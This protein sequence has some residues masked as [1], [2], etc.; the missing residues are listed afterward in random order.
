L[1]IRNHITGT[2]TGVL[3]GS[4]NVI[5]TNSN[6]TDSRGSGYAITGLQNII[7]ITG[8]MFNNNT[9]AVY[10]SIITINLPGDFG[11]S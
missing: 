6:F 4:G 9:H 3:Y 2:N 7:N 10:N 8:C 5:V 11:V 1:P